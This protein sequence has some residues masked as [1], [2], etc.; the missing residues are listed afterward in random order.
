MKNTIQDCKTSFSRELQRMSG[1]SDR[2]EVENELVDTCGKHQQTGVKRSYMRKME[3]M[4]Q[5]DGQ[6]AAPGLERLREN[7]HSYVEPSQ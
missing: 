2:G 1:K 6:G 7:Y 5:V 3:E 4:I